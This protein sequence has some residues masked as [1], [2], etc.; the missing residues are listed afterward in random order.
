MSKKTKSFRFGSDTQEMLDRLA[1]ESNQTAEIEKAIELSYSLLLSDIDLISSYG[2]LEHILIPA[3][4][5]LQMLTAWH[6]IVSPRPVTE[7][8]TTYQ[9]SPVAYLERDV[10]RQDAI[11]YF[12]NWLRASIVRQHRNRLLVMP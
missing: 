10:S 6:W 5:P 7:S 8:G 2:E 3:F 4:N 1:V 11:E 9:L 12:G